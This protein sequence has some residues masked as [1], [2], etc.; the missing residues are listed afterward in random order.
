[1]SA[2][3]LH[4]TWN[5]DGRLRDVRKKKMGKRKVA[6]DGIISSASMHSAAL[7]LHTFVKHAADG[8]LHQFVW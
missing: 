5:A 3:Q 7:L 8:A 4:G 1:M 6:G 2:A